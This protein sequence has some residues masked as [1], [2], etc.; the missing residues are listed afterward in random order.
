MAY[1]IYLSSIRLTRLSHAGDRM[2]HATDRADEVR[3]STTAKLSEALIIGKTVEEHLRG[4]EE[5][6]VD[7]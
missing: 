3:R 5:I 2:N 7:R 1:S 4:A 6:V